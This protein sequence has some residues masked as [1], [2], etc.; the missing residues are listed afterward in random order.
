MEH[1][2]AMKRGGGQM[3]QNVRI[4]SMG[5][6]K[7]N[8][9]QLWFRVYTWNR[10]IHSHGEEHSNGAEGTHGIGRDKGTECR[11]GRG[12]GHGIGFRWNKN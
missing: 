1:D 9:I 4:K 8:M 12:S 6:Q 10:R 5:E 11:D 7:W 3:E 2:V